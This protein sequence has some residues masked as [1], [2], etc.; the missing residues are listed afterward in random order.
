LRTCPPGPA[1]DR[2][3][4]VPGKVIAGLAVAVAPGGDCLADM[5]VVRAEPGRDC[6]GQHAC[7]RGRGWRSRD[8]LH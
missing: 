2:A 5:A 7:E 6:T 3:V 1:A 8:T 4:R